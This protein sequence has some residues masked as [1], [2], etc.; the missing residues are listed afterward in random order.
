MFQKAQ[1]ALASQHFFE[2]VQNSALYWAIQAR[3]AGNPGGKAIEDQIQ[4]VYQRNMKQYYAQRNYAA[5]LA[6]LEEMQKFYPENT[7]LRAE[8]Q[9]LQASVNQSKR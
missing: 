3:K 6:L 2:P 1:T 5:A 9:K 7:A 4:E 8:H